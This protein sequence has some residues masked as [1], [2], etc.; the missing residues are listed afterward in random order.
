MDREA[1]GLIRKKEALLTDIDV[2]ED[3]II[4][5]TLD[6][7]TLDHTKGKKKDKNNMKDKKK[8]KKK[9]KK[10]KKDKKRKKESHDSNWCLNYE[11][12]YY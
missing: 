8:D 10:E 4:A 2:L 1:E 11:E 5:C 7:K 3:L 12:W 6:L 9:E